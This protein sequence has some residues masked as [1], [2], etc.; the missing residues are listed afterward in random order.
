ML[1]LHKGEGQWIMEAAV[2]SDFTNG[3]IKALCK[4]NSSLHPPNYSLCCKVKFAVDQ[5]AAVS[6]SYCETQGF[7]KV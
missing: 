3:L 4:Q 6:P 5:G 7:S 2:P 1:T